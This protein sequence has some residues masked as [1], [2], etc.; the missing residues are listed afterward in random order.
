MKSYIVKLNETNEYFQVAFSPYN[1][2]EELK[3]VKKKKDATLFQEDANI[4]RNERGDEMKIG[5]M[6]CRVFNELLYRK[7]V[8]KEDITVESFDAPEQS[9]LTNK[10]KREFNLLFKM[11]DK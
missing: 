1:T 5:N 7:G 11:F 4:H 6:R 9:L 2:I 3:F 10:Q 8:K